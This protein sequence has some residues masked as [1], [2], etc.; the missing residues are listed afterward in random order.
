MTIAS[1]L[2]DLSRGKEEESKSR[3][4]TVDGIDDDGDLNQQINLH[5]SS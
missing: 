2:M 4:E 1:T 3:E 5:S